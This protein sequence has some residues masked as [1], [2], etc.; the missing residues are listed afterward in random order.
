M[1][2]SV[3]VSVKGVRGSVVSRCCVCLF[4][5]LFFCRCE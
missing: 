3:V 2:V 4:V 1:F 5:C